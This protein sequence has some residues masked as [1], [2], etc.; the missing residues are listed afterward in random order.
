MSIFLILFIFMLGVFGVMVSSIWYMN[1]LM[2]NFIGKKHE[3][4]KSIL[5]TSEVPA[6]WQQGFEKKIVHLGQNSKTRNRIIPVLK[7]AQ[8]SYISRLDK[9]IKYMKTTTMVENEEVRRDVLNQLH[10]TRT[11]WEREMSEEWT[12][13]LNP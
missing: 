5:D 10:Q 3:F 7:K 6:V 4:I 12:Q 1:I 11:Q 9:L 8:K 13:T 2:R